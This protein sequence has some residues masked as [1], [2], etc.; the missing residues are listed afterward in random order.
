MSRRHSSGPGVPVSSV[1]RPPAVQFVHQPEYA[2]ETAYQQESFDPI[3]VSEPQNDLFSYTRPPTQPQVVQQPVYQQNQQTTEPEHI[4][5]LR[6]K[7]TEADTIEGDKITSFIKSSIDDI[8]KLYQDAHFKFRN[9]DI[10]K[11]NKFNQDAFKDINLLRAFYKDILNKKINKALSN[12]PNQPKQAQNQG[13]QFQQPQFYKQQNIP[14]QSQKFTDCINQCQINEILDKTDSVSRR[15]DDDRTS[16]RYDDDRTSRRD[17]DMR[18]S[19]RLV[20]KSDQK[21]ISNVYGRREDIDYISSPRRNPTVNLYKDS[22]NYEDDRTKSI[23]IPRT[24]EDISELQKSYDNMNQ[25][26]KI[27][28]GGRGS[29]DQGTIQK[30]WM[31]KNMIILAK[32]FCRLINK[33]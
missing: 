29:I 12:Q 25:V 14:Q 27:L 30:I 4:K 20:K 23:S 22:Q 2:P 1:V 15:Y 26:F 28:S 17:Y 13:Q 7:L 33:Y 8:K 6:T 21:S 3:R 16:R 31:N 11:D 10:L 5:K 9:R 18:S 24:V 19:P 32:D